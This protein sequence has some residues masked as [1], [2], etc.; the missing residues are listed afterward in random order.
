MNLYIFKDDLA[1]LEAAAAEVERDTRNFDTGL[2]GEHQK[3][4][5]YLCQGKL[6]RFDLIMFLLDMQIIITNQ[7]EP[8][9]PKG[10][11]D[12]SESV[13]GFGRGVESKINR[14]F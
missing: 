3:K 7:M 14:Q 9:M 11:H 6:L 8:Q 5:I 2:A 4:I 1:Y 10:C 12:F 13:E